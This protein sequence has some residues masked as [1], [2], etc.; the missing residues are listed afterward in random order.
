VYDFLEAGKTTDRVEAAHAGLMVQD[1]Q[2]L[3]TLLDSFCSLITPRAAKNTNG[4]GLRSVLETFWFTLK[5]PFLSKLGLVMNHS[6]PFWNHRAFVDIFIP[7]SPLSLCIELWD[8]TL[9]GLWMGASG[10]YYHSDTSLQL[11][12][13]KLRKETTD[14]L[15]ERKVKYYDNGMWRERSV[16][17]MSQINGYLR[18]MK[19]GKA[20]AESAGVFDKRVRVEVLNNCNQ[21]LTGYVVIVLGASRA[22][23]WQANVEQTMYSFDV[24]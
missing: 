10:N 1:V 13:E 7:G 9:E 18:V 5:Y 8:A 22:L 21:N 2:P 19:L 3:I 20:S 14:Q 4:A 23:A 17:S 24:L 15:L 12:Q 6:P 16:K 11:L